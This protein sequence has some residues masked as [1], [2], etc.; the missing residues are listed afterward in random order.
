[1]STAAVPVHVAL[2]DES[3]Q[4]P[5]ADL[6]RASAALQ[7][8]VVRDFAPHWKVAA[9]V[10][11]FPGKAA[12][13]HGYWPILIQA[14]IGEPGAAGVHLDQHHQPYAL[15]QYAADWALTVSHELLEMLA[16]PWGNR[17]VPGKPIIPGQKKASYLVEVCDPC[18]AS[19]YTI[20]GFALS[21]FALPAYYGND[22]HHGPSCFH[23]ALRP[24]TIAH[25][26][27][28][29]FIADGEWWQR[30]WFS[31]ARPTDR[32]LGLAD[33]KS[34]REAVDIAAREFRGGR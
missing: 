7:T 27:Y 13:P 1:M 10:A 4:I 16:D 29:S 17:L 12:V 31:G 11:A 6:A 15:V 3:K 28:L 5:V 21:D 34:L 22:A 33:A 24:R 20:D 25:G 19:T 32:K 8:Q 9:T 26:G 2:V 14:D 18:E 23:S 30:T